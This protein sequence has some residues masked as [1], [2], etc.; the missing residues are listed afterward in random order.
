[1][2]ACVGEGKARAQPTIPVILLDGRG[3]CFKDLS[4]ENLC[5]EKLHG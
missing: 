3:D 4:G 2:V 1:M 5:W